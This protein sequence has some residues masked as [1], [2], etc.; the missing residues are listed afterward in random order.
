M[1]VVYFTAMFPYLVLV[2][3]LIRGITL[4]GAV[5]GVL[6]YLTPKW[7]RLLEAKVIYYSVCSGGSYL[8]HSLCEE[9]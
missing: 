4:D 5:D 7:E 6:F 2:V 3:L 9:G 8:F 1:Q